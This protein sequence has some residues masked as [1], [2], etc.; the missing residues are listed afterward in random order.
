MI[1]SDELSRVSINLVFTQVVQA[2]LINII[3]I[4]ETES[5]IVTNPSDGLTFL[6]S[7]SHWSLK[8]AADA[9][10]RTKISLKYV[11]C[12]QLRPD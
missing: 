6:A 10:V 8:L 11:N 3:N 12:K 9:F 5:E 2:Y 7:F 1:L 4:L